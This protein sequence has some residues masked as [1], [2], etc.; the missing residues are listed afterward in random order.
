MYFVR[1]YVAETGNYIA[2]PESGTA[3]AS[4][5]I[6]RLIRAVQWLYNNDNITNANLTYN[7]TDYAANVSTVIFS[8]GEDGVNGAI[9]LEF[10]FVAD[11]LN[12]YNYSATV[13]DYEFN[14][15]SVN[16]LR[17]AG[18]IRVPRD[19]IMTNTTMITAITISLIRLRIKLLSRN[20][21]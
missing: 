3:N 1:A 21:R 12:H 2:W 11:A 5:E 7:A 20:T 17:L 4:L 19:S 9:T 15:G 18:P 6:D 14:N 10:N 13:S 8:V 16:E